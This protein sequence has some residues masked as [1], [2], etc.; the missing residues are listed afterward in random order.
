MFIYLFF[1]FP[2]FWDIAGDSYRNN[3]WPKKKSQ[4]ILNCEE[5]DI[6]IWEDT[7]EG[8]REREKNLH[9]YW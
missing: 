5:P 3:T 7:D 8:E 6:L 1:L 9:L 2:P 4:H